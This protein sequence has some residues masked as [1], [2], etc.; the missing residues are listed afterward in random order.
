MA[1]TSEKVLNGAG[2][3]EVWTQ[4]KAKFA[5]NGFG[6]GND[7][8]RVVGSVNDVYANGW[9]NVNSEASDRPKDLYGWMLVSGC[10]EWNGFNARQD[11]WSMTYTVTHMYRY[12]IGG[13]WQDWRLA[14]VEPIISQTDITAGSTALA[15]GQSYH[16]Y[17]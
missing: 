11:F 15:E 5:P 12:A 6:L 8:K 10:V 3:A 13:V 17:E 4:A 9:Y 1:N 7:A 16:V 14:P 2:L